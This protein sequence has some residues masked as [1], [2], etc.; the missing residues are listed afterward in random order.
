MTS[1]CKH[2][3]QCSFT[4]LSVQVWIILILIQ[5]STY[6]YLVASKQ[7]F[8]ILFYCWPFVGT[9]SHCDLML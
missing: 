5:L 9:Q 1:N 7:L 6:S 8:Y 4:K 3:Q 2:F